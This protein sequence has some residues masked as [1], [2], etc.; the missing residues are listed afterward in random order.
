MVI[1]LVLGIAR[2]HNTAKSHIL[3]GLQLLDP[4]LDRPHCDLRHAKKTIRRFG[5]IFLK[6]TII[7][8]EAGVFIV[9]VNMATQ[10]HTDRGVDNFRSD[11]IE[12][13]VGDTEFRIPAAPMPIFNL[14]A[15]LR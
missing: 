4:I 8:G 13:L 7:G 12:I 14:R 10:Q 5:A 1:I 6:P 3:G 9:E 2:H 11:A 15:A